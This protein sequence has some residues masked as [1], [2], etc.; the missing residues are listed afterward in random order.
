[1]TE[2]SKMKANPPVAPV[3]IEPGVFVVPGTGN[4]ALPSVHPKLSIELMER[5]VGGV[6]FDDG[7]VRWSPLREI[8]FQPGVFH[9]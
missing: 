1:M 7:G 5:T 4:G 3:E 8:I 9:G 2:K 6:V